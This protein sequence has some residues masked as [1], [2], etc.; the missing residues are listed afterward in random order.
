M[1]PFKTKSPAPG[2]PLEEQLS[3]L[4]DCG[5]AL[6]PGFT[7]DHVLEFFPRQEY[8]KEPFKFLLLTMG[9]ELE[10]EPF[11]PLSDDV[12]YLDTE[13]IEDHGHYV[14]IAE[15]FRALAGGDLPLEDIEDYVDIDEGVAWLRFRLDGDQ[16]RWDAAVD[17]DWADPS[18]LSRFAD[19]LAKRNTPKRFTYLDLR[20]QDCLIGRATPDQLA[21]L[22]QH[23]QLDFQWLA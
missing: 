12:W 22:R 5:I 20:G 14:K 13:C 2:V 7:A 11:E 6:R 9:S 18:I 4:A 19:L 3:V 1:W 10:R 15:R 17:G 23:T 16:I 8:E 21:A